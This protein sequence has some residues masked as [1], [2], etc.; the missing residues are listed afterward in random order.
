MTA[1]H[2]A[3]IPHGATAVRPQWSD[4]PQPVRDLIENRLG[5]SVVAVSNQG[6]GFTP[7]F[8]SRL[9]DD[10]GRRAFVKA[11][12]EEASPVI[13]DCYRTESGI[14]PLLPPGVPAP[15]LR[16]TVEDAG[17]VILGFDDVPGRPPA[18]PWQPAELTQVLTSLTPMAEALTPGPASLVVPDAGDVLREDFG[19]WRQLADTTSAGSDA[20]IAELADL[21]DRSLD[22]LRGDSVVHCDLRDDN[23]IVGD[24]GRVWIC[25]WNWPSRGAAWF[26]LLT[27]LISVRG[28][29][30]DAEALFTAHPL[31]AE[32][33]RAAVD[34]ALAGLSGYFTRASAGPA[35]TTSPHLRTHQSWYAETTLSWLAIRR[36]WVG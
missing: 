33:D 13:A 8:A 34:A 31:G 30:Y 12:S 32:A 23:V 26:D 19:Y 35:L 29:G 24:D 7:G 27:L 22:A 3:S 6:S 5:G 14:V 1:P 36:G 15:P 28:D 11:V 21:D 2:A 9:L 20:Q 10:N 4:L 18:R 16:W 17:W 25:D